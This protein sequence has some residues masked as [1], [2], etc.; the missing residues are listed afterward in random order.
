MKLIRSALALAG[1]A[2]VA[3][4]LPAQFVWTGGSS[5]NGSV[6]DATNWQANTPPTPVGDGTETLTFSSTTG[7]SIVLFPTMAVLD[8]D[9]PNLYSPAYTLAGLG[10]PSTLTLN[11]NMSF[12]GNDVDIDSTLTLSLSAG[13]HTISFPNGLLQLGLNGPIT[14]PGALSF[15]TNGIVTMYGANTYAGGTTIDGPEV[16]LYGSISHPTSDLILGQAIGAHV[17]I[18]GGATVSDNQGRIAIGSNA[19]SSVYVDGATTS[20]TNAGYLY[21]G[22]AGVANMQVTNGATVSSANTSIGNNT[23]GSGILSLNASTLTQTG[24]LYV[25]ALG[26]GQLYAAAGSVISDTNG[27][28]GNNVGGTGGY[29]S[30]S[31]PTTVW[32][33]TGNLYVGASTSG[34]LYV[35]TGASVNA[36]NL[37]IGNAAGSSG[38]VA[39]SDPGSSLNISSSFYVGNGGSGTLVLTGGAVNVGNGNGVIYLGG[40]AG[41]TGS[42]FI[43]DSESG[44]GVIN[45]AA[46]SGGAGI[47]VINLQTTAT[48]A[49]PY[50]LTRDGTASGVPVV[51]SGPISVDVAAG[52]NVLNGNNTYSGGTTITGS[53]TLVAASNNALGT[54]SVTALGT[55]GTLNVASGVTI[56][57]TIV[58]G[59][60]GTLAG[61]GTIASMVTAGTN[62]NLSPGDLIGKLT[63]SNGLIL[64]QNGGLILQIQQAGGAAGTGYDLV[65]VSGGGLNITSTTGNPFKIYLYSLNLTGAAGNVSDFSS[66]TG[67]AWTLFT[68]TGLTNFAANRFAIDTTNFSNSLGL[69]GFAIVQSGNDII[70]DFSPI[71][72]PE[73]WALLASG[74]GAMAWVVRRRRK[75]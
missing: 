7:Q 20:W 39:I 48:S 49:S 27:S 43:G 56:S 72:E 2:V 63:F 64:D 67:Y 23:G 13:T 34:F 60:G 41:S 9:F 58:T 65:N 22:E 52:Y 24:T 30:L 70:L 33:N 25:G 42:L 54:G 44:Q 38:T 35:S 40:S 29:V 1:L 14:G 16:N 37:F 57:N 26:Q 66:S 75:V 31:D 74:L 46:I 47:G 19:N 17:G 3:S 6:Q 62:L 4:S 59:F 73:T 71:P 11:G 8:L 10:G 61:N 5:T 15:T 32:N 53:S 69:G 51:I 50:F 12:G 68:S 21:V 36:A 55:T 45:A 28:I 18:Y